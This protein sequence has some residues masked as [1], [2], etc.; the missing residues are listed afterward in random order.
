[1][2]LE[3]L[4]RSQ[5]S[6]ELLGRGFAWLDTGTHESLLQ[7]NDFVQAIQERQGLKIACIEEIAFRLGYIDQNQLK[8]LAK[9]M[10]KNNYGK[11]LMEIVPEEK[12]NEFY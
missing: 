2:N 8:E 10:L 3:Y 12:T 9:D 7:A 6:V 5:L 11:Y 1:V 4:R